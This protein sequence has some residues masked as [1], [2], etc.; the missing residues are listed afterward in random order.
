M[1][2]NEFPCGVT[3]GMEI[4]PGHYFGWCPAIT[5]K[6]VRPIATG[7][8]VITSE[9]IPPERITGVDV[10]RCQVARQA[11]RSAN[12]IH[13]CSF[14]IDQDIIEIARTTEEPGTTQAD[15]LGLIETLPESL[16][17]RAYEHPDIFRFLYPHCS[18]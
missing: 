10:E 3:I 18:L 1:P 14:L 13:C 17:Y 2:L 11:A 8:G 16:R 15:I 7:K 9:M 12:V 5:R 6:Y 4:V